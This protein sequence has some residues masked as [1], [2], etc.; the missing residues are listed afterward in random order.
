MDTETN[1]GEMR[2]V[3]SDKS[4]PVDLKKRSRR[5]S[6]SA[7][8]S[9]SKEPNTKGSI[10]R[11]SSRRKSTSSGKLSKRVSR[12]G[13]KLQRATRGHKMFF[14]ARMSLLVVLSLLVLSFAALVSPLIRFQKGN[15][16]R[17]IDQ[18]QSAWVNLLL[19][20]IPDST[21][22]FYGDL[23]D[24]SNRP[25]VVICNHL[26][27][28]DWI[29][30]WMIARISKL[31]D[32]AVDRTGNVKIL[33][34]KEVRKMPVFGWGCELFGFI[35]LERDW[36]KDKQVM[37]DALTEFAKQ[38]EPLWLF[39]FVEGTV[40]NERSL[41]KTQA[42]AKEHDRPH[43]E[44]LL[45]PRVRGLQHILEVLNKNGQRSPEVFDVTMAFD[46][47][48]GEVPSWEDTNYRTNDVL[49]PTGESLFAGSASKRVH[50]E[51]SRF[52]GKEL[53]NG[54][55]SLEEWLD[56]RWAR[57]DRMLAYFAKHGHFDA[58]EL[59]APVTIPFEGLFWRSV[60]KVFVNVSIWLGALIAY[61]KH[62]G[63]HSI[64]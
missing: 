40:M 41:K 51:A 60:T 26:T 45:L 49:V 37:E 53:L 35:F 20:I 43:L 42:F 5:I 16:R 23:P 28:V 7:E 21:M 25:K 30:L 10:T 24:A 1:V 38:D 36:T 22:E 15:W 19:W 31:G 32:K 4:L 55:Q 17:F 9:S 50:F 62:Q 8:R 54:D 34:K 13:S 44:H 12:R 29:Y 59:G 63:E 39:I 61:F 6:S 46:S 58:E 14:Y 33:L 2:R 11:S 64:F 18:I 48:T 56:E 3:S 52:S 47:Y 27:E 57:K